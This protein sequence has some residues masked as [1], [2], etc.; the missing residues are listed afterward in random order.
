MPGCLADGCG[1]LPEGKVLSLTHDLRGATHFL[2][3]G[4][5][6]W[7]VVQLEPHLTGF[8]QVW[9]QVEERRQPYPLKGSLA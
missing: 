4:P 3:Q 6:I 9:K 1:W 2:L 7:L 8:Q 5:K